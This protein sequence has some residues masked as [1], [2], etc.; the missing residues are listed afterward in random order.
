ML[1]I[2]KNL[3]ALVTTSGLCDPALIEDF[4]IKLRLGRR[5]RK[6][7][8]SP[9]ARP[10]TY[11]VPYD[12]NAY[13]EPEEELTRGLLL[14]PGD[15]VLACSEHRYALPRGY[16]GLVQ[17]KGSLARLFVSVTCND[18]QIEPGFKG[19]ITLELTNHGRFPVQFSVGD[20]IAQ[21][22]LFRCSMEAPEPYAGRYA[23]AEGPTIAD[24][25]HPSPRSS[26]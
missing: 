6:V 4:S 22:F 24:F 19:R 3:H 18:G 1:I 15:N 20:N 16:F 7:L 5:I 25:S 14:N 8:R 21:L 2:S 26:R 11:N 23:D 12:A 17:T 10:I 9:A 13:F